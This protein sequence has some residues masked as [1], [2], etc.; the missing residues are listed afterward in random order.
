MYSNT[1]TVATSAF[2]K[3]VDLEVLGGGR[4]ESVTSCFLQ[5]AEHNALLVQS[6]VEVV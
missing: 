5:S 4:Q 2:P 3:A 1:N 6:D